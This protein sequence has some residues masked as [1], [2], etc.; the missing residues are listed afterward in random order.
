[1]HANASKTMQMHYKTKR[2][3]E[4]ERNKEKRKERKE[5]IFWWVL[6]TKDQGCDM[7]SVPQPLSYL[8]NVYIDPTPNNIQ[9]WD[10][11]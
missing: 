4:K 1:M 2:K 9:N 6:S 10:T 11:L 7:D 8:L 5:K 3:K